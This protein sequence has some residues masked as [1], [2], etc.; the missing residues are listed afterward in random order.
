MQF[1]YQTQL[2]SDLLIPY[3]QK[4]Y[5]TNPT[6]KNTQSMK[7]AS[8]MFFDGLEFSLNVNNDTVLSQELKDKFATLFLMKFFDREIGFE[9]PMKFILKLDGV[10]YARQEKYNRLFES[11]LVE[12]LKENVDVAKN[13]NKSLDTTDDKTDNGTSKTTGNENGTTGEI[14]SGSGNESSS[15]ETHGTSSGSSDTTGSS[16]SH[17]TGNSSNDKDTSQTTNETGNQTE[18][19]FSRQLVDNVPA[20]RLQITAGNNGTG[21][22]DT[23]SQIVEAKQL[24]NQ[25]T[26]KEQKKTG[27]ENGSESSKSDTNSSGEEHG[28]TTGKEDTN[29]STEGENSYSTKLDGTFNTD[30]TGTGEFEQTSNAVGTEKEVYDDRFTGYDYRNVSQGQVLTQFNNAFVNV[31]EMML[32]DCRE[33]FLQVLI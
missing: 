26:T 13:Y 2:Y 31:F 32:D 3:Q 29:F 12:Y 30:S 18:D 27:T 7:M 25:D 19:N 21:I 28:T 4:I 20:N 9:T 23:A 1:N 17:T 24:N 22:I 10:L 16:E 5:Q 8:M 33:V 11:N 6:L 14:G 15:G